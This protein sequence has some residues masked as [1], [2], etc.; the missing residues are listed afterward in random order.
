MPT[1]NEFRRWLISGLSH[2][3]RAICADTASETAT[4]G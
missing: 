2:E 1:P 3:T 4:T